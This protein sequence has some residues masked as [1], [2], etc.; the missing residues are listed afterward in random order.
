MKRTKSK[1]ISINATINR[2][3]HYLKK[4]IILIP[5]GINQRGAFFCSARNADLPRYGPVEPHVGKK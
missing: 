3:K 4:L 1:K 2:K 5:M